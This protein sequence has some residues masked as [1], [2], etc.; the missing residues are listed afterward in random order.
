MAEFLTC[1]IQSGSH[2]NC[3]YVE[4]DGV[5]LLIDAGVSAKCLRERL[6]G[7]GRT[8]FDID[9]LLITHEHSDHT[10]SLAMFQRKFG[11]PVYITPATHTALGERIEPAEKETSG[12]RL[13]ASGTAT[14]T[15][16]AHADPAPRVNRVPRELERRRGQQRGGGGI[17]HFQAG[18]SFS[19]GP[20]SIHTA[21]TPHDAVDGV[22]FIIEA[23]G[24]RLG[25]FTDLGHPFRALGELLASVNAAYLESNHELDMLWNGDYPYYLKQ[26]I[27][28]PGGHLA[29]HEAADTLAKS[30]SSHLNWVALAHLSA[31]NN[32]PELALEAH[33]RK[34]GAMLPVSIAPRERASA[35]MAV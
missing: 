31:E 10:K 3:I 30:A 27:A 9:A 8:P 5:R 18:E 32:S 12:S 14:G 20:V 34:V 16:W 2:G 24:R 35:F 33:R 7:I 17:V 28:G 4:A 6:A 22:V 15:L 13:Q 25:I 11:V 29:N 26:R 1:S 23:A 21:R 19:I